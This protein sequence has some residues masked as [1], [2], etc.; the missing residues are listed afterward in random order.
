MTHPK[1]CATCDETSCA[2]NAAGR[3]DVRVADK[4]AYILDDV[5]PE[6]ASYV[7][8]SRQ[9]NDQV[10]AP[11]LFGA[12]RLARY[13]WPGVVDHRATVATA[14]R[15]RIMRQVAAK[16]GAERQTAYLKS[17]EAIANALVR[18][19]DYRADHL[20]VAQA[21]LPWL[22]RSGA[23]GG[24]TYDVLMSRFPFA[25]IHRRLDEAAQDYGAS[26]TIGDFRADDH[27]VETERQALNGAR[28][29]LTP[30]YAIAALF[31]AQS[32]LLA[33][34]RPVAQSRKSGARTAFLGPTI[35]RQRPDI[36]RTFA[37]EL[38]TPL[39]VLGRNHESPDFWAGIATEQ[40]PFDANWLDDVSTIIHPATM[41]TQPRALLQAIANG[42]TV[43]ATPACG[44]APDNYR[45]VS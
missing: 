24:R 9:P 22:A 30:H 36:A 19:I 13:R 38:T 39:I 6:Y 16:S 37:R 20:V 21:W 7:Q 14:N 28:K 2:M 35:A 45:P 10:I 34:H 23:L 40:R 32:L 15:H 8:A 5:W 26:P 42:V 18:H 25:D 44:L 41:T 11:G 1:S 12:P 17:D 27:L 4:T 29:I 43:H 33:W 31:P 3:V